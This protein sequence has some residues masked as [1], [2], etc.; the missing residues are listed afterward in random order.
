MIEFILGENNNK[1]QKRN[2]NLQYD[3]NVKNV[4]TTTENP[5]F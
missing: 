2:T 3:I 4:F 5:N 1:H